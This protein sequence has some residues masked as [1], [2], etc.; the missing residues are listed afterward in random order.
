[1]STKKKKKHLHIRK[2]LNTHCVR[3][4]AISIPMAVRDNDQM[5]QQ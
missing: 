2:Y 5:I 4:Y 1:M 3:N